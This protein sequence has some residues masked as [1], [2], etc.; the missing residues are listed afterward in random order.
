MNTMKNLLRR[1][2]LLPLNNSLDLFQE[3]L[4]VGAINH[5]E[6]TM[7]VFIIKKIMNNTKLLKR[8]ILILN[9]KI[10]AI[11]ISD[12]TYCLRVSHMYKCTNDTSHLLEDF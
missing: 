2:A 5:N 3:N 9:D 1:E 7:S 6:A 10:V 12:K 4:N 11:F 8:L